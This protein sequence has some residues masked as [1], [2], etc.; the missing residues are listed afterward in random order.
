M[1]I[2]P[3]R[4]LPLV[5]LNVAL[6]GVPLGCA[7]QTGHIRQSQASTTQPAASQPAPTTQP[8]VTYDTTVAKPIQPRDFFERWTLN[9]GADFR[10][11]DKLMD[12]RTPVP[13]ST[14]SRFRRP[15]RRAP[16][17]RDSRLG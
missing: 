11:V 16:Q 17:R 7:P 4:K 9:R 5:V 15:A 2:K 14:A 10:W 8:A 12:P 6:A 13:R 3:T 1:G